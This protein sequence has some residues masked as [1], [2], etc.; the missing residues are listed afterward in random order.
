MPNNT[1]W[2]V[3]IR[4]TEKL[5]LKDMIMTDIS[6]D[7]TDASRSHTK[8]ITE[9]AAKEYAGALGGAITQMRNIDAGYPAAIYLSIQR[10]D[11]GYPAAI[12]F[13]S[14]KINGGTP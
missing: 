7:A 8:L 11:G 13:P 2:G 1:T 3:K 9:W 6:D 4:A 10:Y 12:Y 5:Q 14:Q